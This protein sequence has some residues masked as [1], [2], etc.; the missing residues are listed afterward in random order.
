MLDT[1][2]KKRI[3]DCRDILVGKIPDPK[4]QVEQITIALIYKF[5]DDMDNQSI[6]MGGEPGFFVGDYARFAWSKI[7]DSSLSG[8]ELLNV[9]SEAISSM[10]KNPN[11]PELF[12]DIFKNAFLPFRDPQTLKMFLK[13]IDK[14]DYDHS[15]RLGD[16]FEYLLSVLGS[17]GDAGQF[18]TPRHIIDFLVAA[19]DP[20]KE[21][22]ICD[23]ACGTAGF[24]ISAY[25]H[26]LAANQQI[27]QADKKKLYNNFVGYDISGDMVRLSLVNMYLH[28]FGN[29]KIFEYDTL[30]SEERWD[31]DFDV[32]LANPPFMSPKGGI[33]PH[34]RFAIDAK[35]SEVLFVDY[36]AEH[37]APQGR[38]GIIVPEGIIFQSQNAYKQLRK[39]LIDKYLWAVVSL[40]AGVFNPYS[41]VKTSILLMDKQ[42][43]SRS[44]Y[45]LFAKVENDGYGLGAQ[46]REIAGSDL[47]DL[48]EYLKQ[49]KAGILR[50]D[51]IDNIAL[52]HSVAKADIAADGDF[53]LSGERYKSTTDHSHVKWPMVRLGEICEINPKKSQ[54]SD[55]PDDIEV[56]FVP[57]ADI[58][59]NAMCFTAKTSKKLGEVFNG[60]TFFQDD[61]VLLAKVTP[62]FENGKAGIAKGLINKIGF[63]SSEFYVLRCSDKIKPELVYYSI[64]NERFCSEGKLKMTGT[65]GL[66]R[67]PKSY[68]ENYLIPLP[69]LSV[70]EELVKELEGYQRIIDGCRQIIENWKPQIKINPDWPMVELG[71]VCE[72]KSGGT[73]DRS[74]DSYWEGDIPWVTTTLIDYGVIDRANE[75]I[76]ASGLKNSSTWIVPKGTILMAMY[77]QGVTRGR[78]AI[79]GIDAAINQACAVFQLKGN[80]VDND[81]LF[82]ILQFRYDDLRMVSDARGGNQSNLSAKVLKEYLIPLPP[83]ATQHA[84]VAEIESEQLVIESNKELMAKYEAKIKQ[85]IAE[86][87][88]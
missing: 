16:A 83:L 54:I 72:I 56:S 80:T 50:G 64:K 29:P 6:E 55:M 38:A 86:L 67:L 28:G 18:R 5:M 17:Q 15:E 9:Y 77:G 12:R 10:N 13:E 70:Q 4:G 46:R 71:E 14:F 27:N 20:Q 53:N 52:A 7:F 48:L 39:M 44:D 19:V 82:R 61:D 58:N 73:P 47:P 57:M 21:D 75:F 32:I 78:V 43:A 68:V 88:E 76:T 79:L 42:L 25:K 24:L 66:Q 8:H 65:G 62:C 30:T 11:L 45:I 81:Y 36:I 35:R 51:T 23:P 41:G 84:I 49:Y 1:E 22:T 3:D 40:P 26:I 74:N 33:T 63:G 85:R 59:D 37:L 60:Y 31:D 87:W 69:P 34:K 2:T